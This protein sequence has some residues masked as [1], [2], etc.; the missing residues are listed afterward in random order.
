[1]LQN[2]IKVITVEHYAS[3]IFDLIHTRDLL[4]W[5]KRLVIEII[6]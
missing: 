3:K 5:V 6:Q 1:M 2:Q 4:G